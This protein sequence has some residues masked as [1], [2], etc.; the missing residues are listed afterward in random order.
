M[1]SETLAKLIIKACVLTIAR[2]QDRRLCILILLKDN[3][4]MLPGEAW[5]EDHWGAGFNHSSVKLIG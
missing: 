3:T 4:G 1:S 5:V 2:S